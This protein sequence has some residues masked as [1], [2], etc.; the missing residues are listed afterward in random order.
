M[1]NEYGLANIAWQRQREAER[2]AAAHRLAVL[3]RLG[4]KVAVDGAERLSLAARLVHRIG[5]MMGAA[6]QDLGR[7]PEYAAEAERLHQEI[8]T[9]VR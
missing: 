1:Y 7:L 2:A 6:V 4:T 3:A 8:R 5:Q 9:S